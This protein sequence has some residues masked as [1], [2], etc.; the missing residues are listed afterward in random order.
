MTVYEAI[1]LMIAFGLLIVAILK[2]DKKK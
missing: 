2:S 1:S